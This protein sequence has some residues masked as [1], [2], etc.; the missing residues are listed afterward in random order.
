MH[1]SFDGLSRP[2]EFI[3]CEDVAEGV[4]AT[5]RGWRLT[6]VEPSRVPGPLLRLKRTVNGYRRIPAGRIPA[7]QILGGQSQSPSGPAEGRHNPVAAVSRFHSEFIDWYLKEHPSLLGLR[8]AA[9][10]FGKGL[11]IFPHTR[12]SR[13]SILAVHLA[14]AGRR[15]FCDD[16]LLIEANNH[17]GM[18]LGILPRM[19]R[20]LPGHGS[21][22]FR[23][24]V[25][26]R[27]GL[28]DSRNAY[29]NLAE[30][31]F[32]PFGKT[33]PII[34]IVL[35]ARSSR[36]PKLVPTHKQD[37][38]RELLRQNFVQ[39]P[40][41]D[42]RDRLRAVVDSARCF[43]MNYATAEEGVALLEEAFSNPTG[44]DAA[45]ETR[46]KPNRQFGRSRDV[47]VDRQSRKIVRRQVGDELFRGDQEPSSVHNVNP[48]AA[49]I[50]QLLEEPRTLAEVVRLLH[51]SHP[52]QRLAK[53]EKD[54]K[55]LVNELE[56]NGLILSK[57]SVKKP[58]RRSE[59][60]E[61]AVF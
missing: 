47:K 44:R 35:L 29:L 42:I 40:A 17:H 43:T 9:V 54:V 55:A 60:V 18:S 19:Q 56:E 3:D 8:C 2:V 50:W 57:D 20:P 30:Q 59:A 23:H 53:I 7:G 31:E 51:A 27:L 46:E 41:L 36:R 37:T 32:A 4:A 24:F 1:V 15:V 45:R 21:P 14:A 5:L 33:A 6:Q 26:S 11:V 10:E 28:H 48:I 16:A 25:K 49:D 52:S 13:K 61:T 38:L 39:A 58:K 12:R 34:G 22:G